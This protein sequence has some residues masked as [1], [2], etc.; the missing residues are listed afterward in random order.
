MNTKK[1]VFLSLLTSLALIISLIEQSLP[2]P[3]PI[4]GAKLGLS[5]VIILTTI[6]VF[7]YRAG[8]V[9]ALLKSLLLMLI[10][11]SVTGF[12]YSFAG[13]L[14]SSLVMSFAYRFFSNRLS[15]IGISELGAV[16]H[17]FGQIAVAA[18]FLSNGG[19][20]AYFPILNLIGLVTGF[21]VGLVA[22]AISPHLTRVVHGS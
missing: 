13:A 8:I 1:L 14:L 5:N 9:V 20:F 4:P 3:L 7:G 12:W 22:N 17:N 15:L 2:L 16:A 11:G 19:L 6:V 21:F 18:F 10:T